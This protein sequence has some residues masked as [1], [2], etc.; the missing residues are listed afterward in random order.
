VASRK[1]KI[2]QDNAVKIAER[3]AEA[4]AVKEEAIAKAKTIALA[5]KEVALAQKRLDIL[6]KTPDAIDEIAA[7][8]I[9]AVEAAL[10]RARAMDEEAVEIIKLEVKLKSLTK[11]IE[12]SNKTQDDFSNALGR[13]IKAF[14][15]VTTGSETLI[16][17][18]FKLRAEVGKGDKEAKK[19][20]K[21][22][23]KM[24]DSLNVGASIV[25]KVIQS[26]LAMAAA[27]DSALASFNKTSGAAGHYNKELLALERT[28]RIHGISTAEL[29]ESYSALMGNVSGFGVMAE[30]ERMRLGELG[31]QYAKTGVSGTD[32]AG[33]I[34][35][36]TR[37]LGMSSTAA[38]GMV[39][40][41]M[42][43]A[44]ALGKDVGTVISELNQTLPKLAS[45]GGDVTHI[46]KDLE[47]QA[48]RTGLEVGELIDIAGRYNTFD[49]A[50]TAAGNLNAVLGTQ[51]FSSMGMLE[52]QLESP[53]A[54]VDYMAENLSN[55]I[56]DWDS[57][58]T[59][60]RDALANA[61]NMSVLEM[62]N[63]M[64]R[65][66][67][68]VE[69]KERE[70][71]M[72]LTMETARSMMQELA[73]LAAEFAVSIQPIFEL[74]KGIVG[75][76]S[77]LLQWGSDF[78]GVTGQIGALITLYL[79]GTFVKAVAKAA[80][81]NVTL[82]GQIPILAAIAAQY[83][84]IAQAKMMGGMGGIPGGGSN[85]IRGRMGNPAS[86]G[87]MRGPNPTAAAGGRMKYSKMGGALGMG[88]LLAGQ[89]IGDGEGGKRDKAAGFL[90]GA[91]GGAAMGAMLGPWGALAGGLI[92]GIGSFFHEGGGV[93]GTG[94]VPATV[95]G[96]EAIVPINKTPAAENLSTMV[97]EKSSA[98]AAV[99]NTAVVA[100]V[101][102]LGLKLD[103]V[104]TA[105]TTS[106]DFG[107]VVIKLN[108]DIV[109]RRI[110][111]Q[112]GQPGYKPIKVRT[113]GNTR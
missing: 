91:G 6:K 77:A 46:F 87:S 4:K 56:G 30:S 59:F 90:S 15:G 61:A 65:R 94:D 113:F 10:A 83:R 11:T 110:N 34:E 28:N 92:G 71:A 108:D 112:L 97:A 43:L 21:S 53:A 16:G 100:A 42:H 111:S 19:F 76:A 55:S 105:L 18:F 23:D 109:G 49:S 72:D 47:R 70:A 13:T 66:N 80:I 96:G 33:S 64:N 22:L 1:D 104:V 39:E 51:L 82:A 5:D 99:D 31:A 2:E 63:M 35:T 25:S 62:S 37:G 36:M 50:A 44:Q 69:E 52:A 27:H 26:T 12:A 101:Q 73:I 68:T 7:A 57:L 20:E 106:G 17:S 107:D 85:L 41:S 103:A 86:S 54:L 48:Q 45:Y 75:K 95:Q 74:F 9:K 29:G 81:L 32:F 102:A 88:A 58:S 3:A 38:S 84:K 78:A 79:V 93:G 8:E 40:E 24:F 89:V 60:Q 67:M 98:A 14:T